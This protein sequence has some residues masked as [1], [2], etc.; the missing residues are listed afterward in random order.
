[1]ARSRRVLSLAGVVL[2]VA[3]LGGCG[4]EGGGAESSA[5]ATATATTPAERPVEPTDPPAAGFQDQSGVTDVPAFGA[6]AEAAQ[7]PRAERALREYL[8][9][10]AAGDWEGA[11]AQVAAITRAQLQEAIARARKV[12]DKSCREALRLTLGLVRQELGGE[13]Y[14]GPARVAALRVKRGGSAGEGAGFALFHGTDGTDYFV[15]M[16]IEDGEWKVTTLA[17]APLG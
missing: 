16:R 12:Q 13:L 7:R 17:P 9:A 3:A 1:M 10:I 8:D 6:E 15:A 11:C 5:P 4:E 14:D 2:L